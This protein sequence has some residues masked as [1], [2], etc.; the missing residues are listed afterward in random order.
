MR[1]F[2]LLNRVRGR[3]LYNS[4]TRAS[5]RQRQGMALLALITLLFVAGDFFFFRRIIAYLL[6]LPDEISDLL[7]PQFLMVICLTFF[8]MLVFS[9]I[10]ASI[11]TF[12]LSKDLDLLISS[13]VGMRDIFMARYLL[14]TVNSSWMFLIFGVPIFLALGQC[15]G[16]GVGYYV[17]VAFTVVPFILIPSCLGILLTIVLMRFFPA[18]KTYQFLTVIGL[19]F[20]GILVMFFR[21]LQP[22]KF[23]GKKVPMEEIQRFVENL[24]IPSYGFLPSTWATKALQL[25]TKGD[26]GEMAWWIAVAW[27]AALALMALDTFVVSRIYYKGWSIAYTG[28]SGIQ[29]RRK[30]R[31][32]PRLERLLGFLSA[33][34]RAII[35]KDIRVFWRDPS[36]WTQIFM[37]G[38]LV[39]VYIFNIRSLPME[40][41]FLKNFVSVMNI[42]LAGVVLAAVALRFVFSSVSTEARSFWLIKSAPLDFSKYLWTKFFFYL[43][44]LLILAETLVVASN[45][46]LDVDPFLMAVSGG[47]IFFIT[48]GL[49]GLGI[50]LGAVYPV[51]EHDNIA[52]IGASTGAVYYMIISLA[53]VGV[54]V[55]FGLRPVWVYFSQKFLSR[56]VGGAEVYFCYAVIVALTALVTVLPIRWGAAALKRDEV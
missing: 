15:S 13:P 55:M 6:S 27:A 12:Y 46:F 7:I 22:E 20:M 34:L 18:R 17:G 36:Q 26:Y 21:F 43:M 11:S 2:L 51:F 35:L 38:A 32:Y 45:L 31:F 37:L 47:G 5:R 48:V 54:I 19:V 10:I 33:P 50:G 24:K 8:S 52:E 40:S 4:I 44:P 23:L 56:E 1:H 25:G 30:S 16:A 49:T 29:A 39:A 28:R 3:I 42:G 14:T 9:N 41:L 53:Y